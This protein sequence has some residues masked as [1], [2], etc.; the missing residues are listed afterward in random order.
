MRSKIFIYSVASQFF[1]CLPSMTR[2]SV[3]NMHNDN[4][5]DLHNCQCVYLHNRTAQCSFYAIRRQMKP[6]LYGRFV[7][8]KTAFK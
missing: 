2:K 8:A 3:T 7:D 4:R 5:V 6:F 1:A